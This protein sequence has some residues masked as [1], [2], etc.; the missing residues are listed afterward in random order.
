MVRVDSA[1]CHPAGTAPTPSSAAAAWS[2]EKPASRE[3]ARRTC[4]DPGCPTNGRGSPDRYAQVV[5]VIVRFALAVDWV[6]APH[7][8]SVSV[9]V[10]ANQ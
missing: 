8:A 6:L 1:A 4:I 2:L 10:T 7:A 9:A 5:V 3:Y